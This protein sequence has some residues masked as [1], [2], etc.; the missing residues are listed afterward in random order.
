M[1]G[2]NHSMTCYV[3]NCLRLLV[4]YTEIL[5]ILLDDSND[6]N[7]FPS[8]EAQDE[9]HLE[10][11]TPLGRRLVKLMSY[12]EANSNLYENPCL[13]CIFAMHNLLYIV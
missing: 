1:A 5:D 9:E 7:P 11:M 4:V 8:S 12:L 10:S 3:M 2:E 13:K 6:D